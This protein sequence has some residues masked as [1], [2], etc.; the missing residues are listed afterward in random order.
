MVGEDFNAFGF[1]GK[2]RVPAWIRR[3][4]APPL[5]GT[6]IANALVDLHLDS[7]RVT[8]RASDP[9]NWSIT[10]GTNTIPQTGDSLVFDAATPIAVKNDLPAGFELDG[11]DINPGSGGSITITGN[12]FSL[13][14]GGTSFWNPRRRSAQVSPWRGGCAQVVNPGTALTVLR[15]HSEGISG[16]GSLI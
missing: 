5:R 8:N 11:I 9:N 14:D 6:R 15:H 3:P 1:G 13:P 2:S 7:R 12:S 16:N 10:G 4:A